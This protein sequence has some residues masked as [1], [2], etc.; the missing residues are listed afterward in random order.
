M[1]GQ[2]AFHQTRAYESINVSMPRSRPPTPDRR[3]L[4]IPCRPGILPSHKEHISLSQVSVFSIMRCEREQPPMLSDCGQGAWISPEESVTTDGRGRLA[5]GALGSP[6]TLQSHQMHTKSARAYLGDLEDG[7]RY[8]FG[9][10]PTRR[11]RHARTLATFNL[12]DLTFPGAFTLD[13]VG[14]R[15]PWR[16]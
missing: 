3:P 5:T 4:C 6:V 1:I 13:E 14:T 9:S 12:G 7:R 16:P 2:C 8:L 10:V 15:I 11:T